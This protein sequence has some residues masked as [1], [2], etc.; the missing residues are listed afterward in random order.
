[1]YLAP[2]DRV[3]LIMEIAERLATK[4]WC[5][6]DLTLKEFSLPWS[7]NYQGTSEDYVIAMLESAPDRPLILLARP[8]GCERVLAAPESSP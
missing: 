3:R 2:S 7:D 6:I 4:N 5:I 8:L 1:M